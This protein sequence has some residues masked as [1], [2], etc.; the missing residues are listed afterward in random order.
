MKVKKENILGV[1]ITLIVISVSFSEVCSQEKDKERILLLKLDTNQFYSDVMPASELADYYS[2]RENEIGSLFSI[3]LASN[4]LYVES[5]SFQY[6]RPKAPAYDSIRM[7]TA[8]KTMGGK[9]RP[10]Y[11]GALPLNSDQRPL[12]K[13]LKNSKS[14]FFLSINL[15]EIL[16]TEQYNEWGDPVLHVIHY[17]L[18]TSDFE[19]ISS[20]RYQAETNSI[21]PMDMEWFFKDFALDMILWSKASMKGGD[22]VENYNTLSVELVESKYSIEGEDGFGLHLGFSA[23]YGGIG[24][25]YLKTIGSNFDLNVGVGYDFSGFKI[26]FG[27]RYYMLGMKKP[28]KPF[29]GLNYAFA[30]GQ[31]ITLGAI[32][33]EDGQI[34]N[35]DEVSKYKVYKDHALH[36]QAGFTWIY[37]DSFAI[38]PILGYA[39]PFNRT[40]TE[41]ISGPDLPFRDKMVNAMGVGGFFVGI[42]FIT[43]Y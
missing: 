25:E 18:F 27:S 39:Y 21:Y 1:V 4:I 10:E 20:G 30:S 8:Y 33:D 43:F 26:G 31:N 16:A 41:K 5:D 6:V 38:M 11:L 36:L 24:L 9:D 13:A 35:P 37:M 28:I 15:Y 23:P 17:E 42:T 40:V 29:V 7:E 32:K 12:K 3:Y 22:P 2:V 14:R 34:L 19:L